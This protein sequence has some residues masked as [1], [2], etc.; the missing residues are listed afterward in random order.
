MRPASATPPWSPDGRV[1]TALNGGSVDAYT[2]DGRQLWN[3]SSPQNAPGWSRRGVFAAG[4]VQ[5]VIDVYDSRGERVFSVRG[6]SAAWSPDGTRLAVL[7]GRRLEV[8]S[9]NGGVTFVKTS[10]LFADAEGSVNWAANGQVVAYGRYG[11]V[12]VDLRTGRITR[13]G[14]AHRSFSPALPT[15]G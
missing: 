7:R 11:P 15:A 9:T 14:P 10:K 3:A 1:A 5:G 13:T 6:D 12:R 4:P 8:L 2:T